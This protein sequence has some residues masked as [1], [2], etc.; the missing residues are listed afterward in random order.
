MPMSLRKC[1]FPRGSVLA[2][3]AAGVLL[4]RLSVCV[5]GLG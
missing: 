4:V 2:F 5:D 3:V 1:C